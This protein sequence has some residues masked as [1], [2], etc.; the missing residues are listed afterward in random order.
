MT[1]TDEERD[2]TLKGLSQDEVIAHA[3]NFLNFLIERNEKE[4]KELDKKSL[5]FDTPSKTSL[6]IH[7]MGLKNIKKILE[8]YERKA[9]IKKTLEK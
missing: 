1:L 6:S 3:L 4:W 5:G 8:C 9:K 2:K 7:K